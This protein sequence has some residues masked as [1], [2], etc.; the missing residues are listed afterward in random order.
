MTIS[1][2]VC[3]SSKY[4]CIK[5]LLHTYQSDY[6]LSEKKSYFTHS[7]LSASHILHVW[8]HL[9]GE[10]LVLPECCLLIICTKRLQKV[11]K[12]TMKGIV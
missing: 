6:N 4:T 11:S 7:F 8:F 5:T 2:Q 12:T 9:F 1:I 3:G 10:S